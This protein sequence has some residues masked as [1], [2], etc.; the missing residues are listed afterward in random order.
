MDY[1]VFDTVIDNQEVLINLLDDILRELKSMNAE[2]SRMLGEY[3][4][5]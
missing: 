1:D 4:D 3:N 2:M 5:R